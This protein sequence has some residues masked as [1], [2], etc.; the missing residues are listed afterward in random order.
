VAS[1]DNGTQGFA[2]SAYCFILFQRL[3]V[4]EGI[5]GEIAQAN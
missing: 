5:T 1:G 3:V 4:A 2:L